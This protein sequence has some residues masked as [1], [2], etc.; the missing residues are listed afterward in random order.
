MDFTR[1]ML[2]KSFRSFMA[3]ATNFFR[4]HAIYNVSYFVSFPIISHPMQPID[5]VKLFALS[6]K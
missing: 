6:I 3:L 5:S 2:P 1:L 4:Q